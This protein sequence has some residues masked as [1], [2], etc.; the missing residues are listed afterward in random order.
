MPATAVTWSR[1]T[2]WWPRCTTPV[3]R[4]EVHDAVFFLA[5]SRMGLYPPGRGDEVD[6]P[7]AETAKE[8]GF[9]TKGGGLAHGPERRIAHELCRAEQ[10]REQEACEGPPRGPPLAVRDKLS[11]RRDTQFA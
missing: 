8:F 2:P 6:L 4:A 10:E 11:V 5:V 1:R 3:A 7:G 9:M